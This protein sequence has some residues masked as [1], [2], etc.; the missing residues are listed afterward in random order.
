MLHGNSIIE[1][2]LSSETWV[3]ARQSGETRFTIRNSD[4][5]KILKRAER[6]LARTCYKN[7]PFSLKRAIQAGKGARIMD[8]SGDAT[9]FTVVLEKQA[10][11]YS[12]QT[13]FAE[14]PIVTHKVDG[15]HVNPFDAMVTRDQGQDS[16]FYKWGTSNFLDADEI[17]ET[18][19]SLF[20][21]WYPDH[22]SRA[23]ADESAGAFSMEGFW[24]YGIVLRDTAHIEEFDDTLEHLY[25]SKYGRLADKRMLPKWCFAHA[26]TRYS[27]K[28][29]AKRRSQRL[30]RSS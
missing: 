25:E 9:L 20:A 29:L 16:I 5:S 1:E 14:G 15:H 10:H 4:G 8:L 11:V 23:L 21:Q 7:N 3:K 24:V 18:V 13:E 17:E 12:F 27:L 2:V 19:E 30:C 28:A 6:W 22:T 26:E